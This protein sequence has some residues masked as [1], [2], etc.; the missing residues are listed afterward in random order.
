MPSPHP[1]GFQSGINIIEQLTEKKKLE[2]K[3]KRQQ[4]KEKKKA[5][6]AAKKL[7]VQPCMQRTFVESKHNR[8]ESMSH[9]LMNEFPPCLSPT[10]NQVDVNSEQ[11]PS[12]KKK[13][14]KHQTVL[15]SPTEVGPVYGGFDGQ[16][17]SAYQMDPE[18]SDACPADDDN[19]ARENGGVKTEERHRTHSVILDLSTTSFV[20]TVTAKTLNNV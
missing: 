4:E 14:K 3:L 10:E 11:N 6:K 20:D 9:E 5:K 2:N 18:V 16:V 12:V 1:A 13:G 17:N 15:V 7:Q 19:S 8:Y